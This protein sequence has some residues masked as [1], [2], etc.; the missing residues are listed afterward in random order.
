MS[1]P[2]QRTVDWSARLV[3]VSLSLAMI[4]VALG[5]GKKWL[6]GKEVGPSTREAQAAVTRFNGLAEHGSRLGP[7]DAPVA[8][9][10]FTDYQCPS[11]AKFE[12]RLAL[13]RSR[14]EEPF[15]VVVRHAPISRIHPQARA[16]A[17]AAEC[18]GV[19]GRFS[20]MHEALFRGAA[21]I[22]TENWAA[23]ATAAGV[24]DSVEFSRCMQGDRMLAV[25]ARDSIATA[26][27]EFRGT[28]TLVTAQTLV[29]GV[30]PDGELE[31]LIRASLSSGA[32]R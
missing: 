25:I 11:C 19:G 23:L 13:V 20:A 27:I 15:A 21:D 12:E 32:H 1:V 14:I 22:A 29:P 9:V 5:V 4:V 24:T 26:A 2:N 28:P 31:R 10:V 17:I 7:A 18:A 30:P 8:L 6:I 3:N 16:A